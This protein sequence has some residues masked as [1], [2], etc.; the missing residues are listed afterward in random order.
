MKYEFV[1]YGDVFYRQG[2]V[3]RIEQFFKNMDTAEELIKDDVEKSSLHLVCRDE[4]KVL[5]TG[6]LTYDETI[7]IISQMAID[8]KFQKKGIGSQILRHLI[9]ECK[10]NKMDRIQLSARETAINF[11]KKYKFKTIGKKYPS[12]KTGIIHQQM[13]LSLLE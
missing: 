2:V 9:L 3:I 7:G 10:K 6:R 5:G 4:N 13:E 12:K 8:S 1:S 11:Y